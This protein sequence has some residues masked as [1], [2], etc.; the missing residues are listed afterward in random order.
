[1]YRLC[2]KYEESRDDIE[3]NGPGKL[4]THRSFLPVSVSLSLFS[5]FSLSFFPSL[6]LV[7]VFRFL[8]CATA[9]FYFSY[10]HFMSLHVEEQSFEWNLEESRGVEGA[11]E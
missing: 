7:L 1:M 10:G 6:C 3:S 4:K 2:V 11:A 5:F 8:G 9:Y